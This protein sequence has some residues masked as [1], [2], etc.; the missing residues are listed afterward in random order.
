MAQ[1]AQF[2]EAEM[3]QAQQAQQQEAEQP[4]VNGAGIFKDAQLGQAAEVINN[5]K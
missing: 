3:M 2:K 4:T 5:M 1:E